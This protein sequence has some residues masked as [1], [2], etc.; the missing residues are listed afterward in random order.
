MISHLRGGGVVGFLDDQQVR[1]AIDDLMQSAVTN[2]DRLMT[3]LMELDW[4]PNGEAHITI[5]SLLL[6]IHHY[7]FFRNQS[8][9]IPDCLVNAYVQ[10]MNHPTISRYMAKVTADRVGGAAGVSQ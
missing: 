7:N 1:D 8:D 2:S 3:R 10:A 9:D 5:L 4:K 6:I